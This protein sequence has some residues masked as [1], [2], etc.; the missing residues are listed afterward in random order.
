[1]TISK[2]CLKQSFSHSKLV[3]QAILSLT[4]LSN[5]I[6]DSLKL[7][8]AFLFDCTKFCSVFSGYLKG[9]LMTISKMCLKQSFSHSK[10]VLQAI[11]SL[12]IP[13]NCISGSSNFN[14]VFPT[15]CTKCCSIF[16]VIGYEI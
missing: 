11:L 5:C 8:T 2:M 9:N 6:S 4:V 14:T 16:Q 1:M 10:L 3:L 7:D 15:D 12:T 13:S